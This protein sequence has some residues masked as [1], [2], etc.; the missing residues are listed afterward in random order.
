MSVDAF[1][2]LPF[3]GRGLRARYYANQ[4]FSGEPLLTALENQRWISQ[5]TGEPFS[6]ELDGYWL[7]PES[8]TYTL[9]LD[10]DEGSWLYLDDELVIDRGGARGLGL[11]NKKIEIRRGV[12]AVRVRYYQKMADPARRQSGRATLR[13]LWARD[14]EEL[15]PVLPVFLF[16]PDDDQSLEPL[17][18][19]LGTAGLA[20]RDRRRGNRS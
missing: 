12:H 2:R 17:R 7:F 13:L 19:S 6:L 20:A 10:S 4:E 3:A 11:I 15:Q 16:P 8:G 14:G 18:R 1:F 5:Q 9:G